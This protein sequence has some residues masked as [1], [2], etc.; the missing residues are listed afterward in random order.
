LAHVLPEYGILTPKHV[1]VISVLLYVYYTLGLVGCN[2]PK[3]LSD[4]Q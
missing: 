3:Y 2:I 4:M 1:G